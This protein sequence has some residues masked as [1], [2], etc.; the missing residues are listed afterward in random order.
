MLLR[1]PKDRITA[2]PSSPTANSREGRYQETTVAA[3]TGR[4]LRDHFSQ[5]GKRFMTALGAI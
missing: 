2:K 3:A 5:L 1:T 4:T